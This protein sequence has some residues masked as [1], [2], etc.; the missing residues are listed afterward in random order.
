MASLARMVASEAMARAGRCSGP[1]QRDVEVDELGAEAV[2]AVGV[3]T[4]RQVAQAVDAIGELDREQ[5]VGQG[6][7]LAVVGVVVA[8]SAAAAGEAMVGGQRAER[9]GGVGAELVGDFPRQR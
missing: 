9:L 6:G 3:G 5:L 2:T 4:D 8:R 1:G 7:D